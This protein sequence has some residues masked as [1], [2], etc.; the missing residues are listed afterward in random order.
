MGVFSIFGSGFGSG[1]V[2]IFSTG[3]GSGFGSGLVTLAGSGLGSTFFTGAGFGGSDFETGCCG[4]GVT[5]GCGATST[6]SGS[7]CSA[8]VNNSISIGFS[9]SGFFGMG[10]GISNATNAAATPICSAN[11]A[12]IV[13][14]LTLT[15]LELVL[16]FIEV[17]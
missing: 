4:G 10:F 16:L 6:T 1:C 15:G 9:I 8:K 2:L 3:F 13:A 17:K 12:I 11:T 5:T 7:G 14:V